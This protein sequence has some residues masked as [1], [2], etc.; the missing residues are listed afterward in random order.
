MIPKGNL[1]YLVRL[2][3]SS[4]ETPTF[5]WF[6]VVCEFKEVFSKDLLEFPP[7]MEINFGI[8]IL[9]D[10]QPISIPPQRMDP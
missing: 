10:T 8:Y 1:Y 5:E 9:P 3:D 2:K 7:E 6:P 4:C